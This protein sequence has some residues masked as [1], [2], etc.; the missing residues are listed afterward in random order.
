VSS[1]FAALPWGAE[2]WTSLLFLVQKQARMAGGGVVGLCLSMVQPS[3]SKA[4]LKFQPGH[5]AQKTPNIYRNHIPLH[6]LRLIPD[7]NHPHLEIKL[8]ESMS[9]KITDSANASLLMITL[10]YPHDRDAL[11]KTAQILILNKRATPSKPVTSRRRLDLW[12][13]VPC[14]S[15]TPV[16]F[17]S[18][19]S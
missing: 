8:I 2:E 7:Y 3:P 5:P 15:G 10:V 13:L 9:S 11:A 16:L 6:H 4:R 1:C 14:H 17:A 19:A 18:P 12:V